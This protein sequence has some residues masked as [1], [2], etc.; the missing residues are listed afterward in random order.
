MASTQTELLAVVRKTLRRGDD[1]LTDTELESFITFIQCDKNGNAILDSL[2]EAEKLF[3]NKEPGDLDR[4]FKNKTPAVAWISSLWTYGRFELIASEI[5]KHFTSNVRIHPQDVPTEEASGTLYYNNLQ[6][7]EGRCD[8][9]AS[10]SN[11]K[12]VA[13]FYRPGSKTRQ[14]LIAVFVGEVDETVLG[15]KVLEAEGEGTWENT[16]DKTHISGPN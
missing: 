14:L 8:V 16:R 7:L 3:A 11:G 2:V 1:D 12:L 9:V 15:V 13:R 4:E 10:G 5:R 6:D